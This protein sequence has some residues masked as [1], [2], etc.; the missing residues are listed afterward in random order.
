M[1]YPIL[2]AI[3][4]ILCVPVVT[5]AASF[6]LESS[7]SARLG[8][9]ILIPVYIDAG[10]ESV[11]IADLRIMFPRESLWA[12]SFMVAPGW[13]IA[14][15]EEYNSIDNGRGTLR[16]TAGF[17]GGF[18]G[19][20]PF[21][22]LEFVAVGQGIAEIGIEPDSMIL[23]AR[24]ENLATGLNALTPR[25]V[26]ASLESAPEIPTQLF[27][28]RLELEHQVFSPEDPIIIRAHFNSFG[29]VPTPVEI[30]FTVTDEFGKII[31]ASH[32]SLVVETD[33]VFTKRFEHLDLPPGAYMVHMSTR[34]NV[35]VEDDFQVAFSVRSRFSPLL[36]VFGAVLVALFG[37]LIIS[38]R[39][40][41]GHK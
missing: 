31:T 18:S 2:T 38:K 8:D 41:Y 24:N 5:S 30:F 10:D 1:K 40:N 28:I 9:T 32:E 34:Y 3:I 23:N 36:I 35:H 7:S 19:R 39:H 16:A 27:D 15:G 25:I 11:S 20:M 17:E 4:I 37:L 13:L 22:T 26:I 14:T 6:E 21:G 33:A 29:T 12:K